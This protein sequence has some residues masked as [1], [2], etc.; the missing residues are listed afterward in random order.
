[1][2]YKWDV[3]IFQLN[4]INIILSGS[5]INTLQLETFKTHQYKLKLNEGVKRES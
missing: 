4:P 5:D 1:M 2:K 3:N